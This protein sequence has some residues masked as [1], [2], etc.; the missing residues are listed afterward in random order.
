MAHSFGGA[1]TEILLDRDLGSAGVAISP[2]PI[3]GVYNTPPSS[4]KVASVALK[5]PANRHKAVT[6]TPEQ[7]HYGFTNTL[8]DEE[9]QRAYKRYAIPG[10]GRVLFQAAFSN[11]QPG[12][13]LKVHT[14]RPRAPLLLMANGQD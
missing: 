14:D 2:A 12:S 10:P 9:S 1:I 11:L 6:L 13:P 8:S 4:F 5:N 3:K 7:F